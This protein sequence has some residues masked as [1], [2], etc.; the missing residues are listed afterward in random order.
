V[1][2]SFLIIYRPYFS[3]VFLIRIIL[4]RLGNIL[5]QAIPKTH[6][7][8]A[9]FPLGFSVSREEL[10]GYI[11]SIDDQYSFV[12]IQ[13]SV[14]SIGGISLLRPVFALAVKVIHSFSL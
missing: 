9:I 7:R 13:E 4:A 10:E 2:H 6:Q 14:E 8:I 5:S 12:Q 3:D 1:I 11:S